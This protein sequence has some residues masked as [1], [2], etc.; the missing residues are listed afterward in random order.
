[1]PFDFNSPLHYLSN[2]VFQLGYVF[3]D[4]SKPI[5]HYVSKMGSPGFLRLPDVAVVDQTY[6]GEP[7]ECRQNIAFGFVGIMNVE[8]I[9][10]I[11]GVSSYSEF[12]E[13]NPDGGLHHVGC[14][15]YDFDKA[16]AD[17]EGAGCPV[18]QTGRFGDAT[19]F[20]YCDTRAALGHF[21]EILYFDSA[22]Q[23]L[24]EAIRNGQV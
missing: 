20:A 10:P 1:M 5:D 6:L 13:R 19:R 15:V 21:T 4:I 12:L 11:S 17:M 16:I 14:K 23:A 3:P 8:L 7:L 18:I 24:F 22:T 9:E 2:S